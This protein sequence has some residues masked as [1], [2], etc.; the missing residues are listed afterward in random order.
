MRGEDGIA[1]ERNRLLRQV[2]QLVLYE[3]N[4]P[5][6]EFLES[7]MTFGAPEA[8]RLPL[9][10][11]DLYVR[12]KVDRIDRL[13]TQVLAVKDLKTGRVRDFGEEPI[14]ATRD[15]QIGLYVLALEAIGYGGALVGL[16]GYVH[17]SAVREPDRSFE[18]PN[19]EILRRHT[20]EWL[21]IAQVLL[22]DGLFPR[23][24]NSDDC[25]YCPYVA[26]CGS[27][28]A[29]RAAVKLNHLPPAHV[30]EPFAR[31]KQRESELRKQ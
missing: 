27:G 13:S 11:G 23:T 2:E 14:N 17:P 20:R 8:V 29:Q 5:A 30:L 28:A 19:V 21:G 22:R 10:T 9:E 12:G 18:G 24:P 15:L 1:R 4:L 7:E 6:R 16:A 25:K 31:F 3:W 26:A